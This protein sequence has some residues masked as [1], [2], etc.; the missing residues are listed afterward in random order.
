[1]KPKPDTLQ[2]IMQDLLLCHTPE[3]KKNQPP[4][5]E[6]PFLCLQNLGKNKLVFF[7]SSCEF[8]KKR[9]LFLP[10][11]CQGRQ[12]PPPPGA[13]G[14][15]A[16]GA[17]LGWPLRGGCGAWG[18]SARPRAAAGASAAS[19]VLRGPSRAGLAACPTGAA[20]LAPARHVWLGRR[21]PPDIPASLILW[22]IPSH[23]F[24]WRSG[25]SLE[26]RARL[27]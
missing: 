18:S 15:A 6:P 1:M 19:A 2:S 24:S 17:L 26:R 8:K 21:A 12:S 9:K 27:P 11:F 14:P 23:R 13:C 25:M 16:G 4:P 3:I 20:A 22:K 10:R 5:S 7:F